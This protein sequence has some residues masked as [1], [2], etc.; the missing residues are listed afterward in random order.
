MGTDGRGQMSDDSNV[1]IS[2]VLQDTF[3]VLQAKL[4]EE[5]SG[6]EK[7]GAKEDR[8]EELVKNLARHEGFEVQRILGFGGMGAVVKATDMKLKR[9]VALKFLPPEVIS[10]AKN[11]QELRGE[12]EMASRIQHENVV[13]IFSWHEIES[14]PFFAMEFIEGETVDQ[15]VKRRG[16]LSPTEA[17]RIIAEASRGVEALHRIG[18][19]HRDIKPQNILLSQ[20]GRVKITDFGISRTQDAISLESARKNSI[21]GT[22]RF[23][24]PEQARGEAAT[25]QSD[26]YSLGAT[27][28]FMLT[29][30]APVEHSSQMRQQI[31]NVRDGLV[32]PVTNVL[33]KLDKDVARLVMRTLSAKQARR[34]WDV[35]TL[36]REIDQIF[37]AQTLKESSPIGQVFK[38]Q[39]HLVLPA[40]ALVAGVL[41][42]YLIPR[43][44]LPVGGRNNQ[45]SFE[46]LQPSLSIRLAS[47]NRVLDV[48][49]EETELAFIRDQLKQAQDERSGRKAA[50]LLSAAD[51]GLRRWEVVQVARREAA[52][53]NSPMRQDATT[54]LSQLGQPGTS[55]DLLLEDWWTRWQLRVRESSAATRPA[56]APGAAVASPPGSGVPPGP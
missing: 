42:G 22:P 31:Q 11:A 41:V 4:D 34:P 2:Q 39:R 28:Y 10:D 52:D 27:L 17:L 20:D 43:D 37:L 36:N 6:L 25:K 56:P 14:V 53:P 16:R 18:I 47:L 7:Q 19:I 9:T 45:V 54:L 5:R 23:M 48:S 8:L 1:S 40:V 26:I 38:K 35:P 33:P 51:R 46:S 15:L 29:G 32:V 3:N 12:A 21:A 49:P 30:R 55:Q 13:Q 44:L 24:S 50:L